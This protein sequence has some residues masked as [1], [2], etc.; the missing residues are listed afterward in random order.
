MNAP[1]GNQETLAPNANNGATSVYMMKA[2][3]NMQSRAHNYRMPEPVEKGKE[4][5]NP[6]PPL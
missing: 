1:G 4:A 2:K 6:L 3:Y 5:P